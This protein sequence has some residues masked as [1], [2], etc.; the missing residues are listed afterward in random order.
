MSDGV[1]YF[2]AYQCGL[3]RGGIGFGN[4]ATTLTEPIRSY[5]DVEWI[6]EQ[7]RIKNPGNTTVVI[8]SW[9]RFEG[10]PDA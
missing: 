3:A 7:I 9:Q 10:G 6:A 1:Q 2:F 4:Y 5:E 8:L